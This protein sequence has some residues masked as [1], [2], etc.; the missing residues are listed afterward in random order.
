DDDTLAAW[1]SGT[2]GSAGID[3]HVEIVDNRATGGQ[4]VSRI[5]I[6]SDYNIADSELLLKLFVLE[7]G[8]ALRTIRAFSEGTMNA[9][10]DAAFLTV[11][12][13]NGQLLG[14]VSATMPDIV[15]FLDGR[16]SVDEALATLELTGVFE[17]FR[18]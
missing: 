8:N 14:T 3:A 2:I 6:V 11:T 9:D 18:K 4:R 5:T 12:D 16:S 10:L 1:M 15:R 7:V 17:T 13:K